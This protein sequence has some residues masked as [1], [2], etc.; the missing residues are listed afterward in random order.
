MKITI[1]LQSQNLTA[2]LSHPISIA[3]PIRRANNV[4]AFHLSDPQFKVVRAGDFIGDVNE[5]GSCNVEN[6]HFSPH[7]NGTHTEC[8]GHISKEH[9][10][11]KDCIN[12]FHF[13]AQLI[14]L[15]I[16]DQTAITRPM[17]EKAFQNQL[18]KTKALVIRT[19]PNNEQ[20]LDTN[21]SGTQPPYFTEEA[22]QFTLGNGI[23][24][25]LTDLPSLDHED[26]PHL[27][28]HHQF[29]QYPG[30]PAFHRTVTEF[31]YVPN[32]IPDGP[33]LL[34][35]QILALESDASPSQPVLYA[36]DRGD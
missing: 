21:Y 32:Q 11:L 8:I 2:D 7:G 10:F 12:Q 1:D 35:L 6:L 33:Y 5:G 22:I 4:N 31:I 28:A 18:P 17:L 30:N 34:N 27:T 20:K 26:D 29:F 36:L 25:L 16:H 14:S 24:H 23:D 19:L 15:P 3:I 9:H 13:P